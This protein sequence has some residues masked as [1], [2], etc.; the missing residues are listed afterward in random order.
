[1]EDPTPPLDTPEVVGV[2]KPGCLRAQ[3]PSG[4]FGWGALS[5]KWFGAAGFFFFPGQ[6][7]IRSCCGPKTWTRVRVAVP[8]SDADR[9]CWARGIGSGFFGGDGCSKFSRGANRR[10]WSVFPLPR[11]VFWVQYRFFF[12]KPPISGETLHFLSWGTSGSGQW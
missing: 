2:S 1:M 3:N 7:K 12:K 9:L 11:L 10:S 6:E 4:G 8:W 5:K